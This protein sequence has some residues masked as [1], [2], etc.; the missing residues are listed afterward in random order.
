MSRKKNYFWTSYSDLMTSLFLIMLVLFVMAFGLF[1]KKE[2]ILVDTADSLRV[3]LHKH[4]QILRLEEQMKPLQ[5]DADFY[6]LAEC[7]K[8]V[9]RGLMGIEIFNPFETE[10]IEEYRNIAIDAGRKI[11]S[12]LAGLD[13]DLQYLLV[14]EGNTANTYDWRYNED[15]AS[16]YLRSYRRA[17][18][19]YNLWIEND[20]HFRDYNVEVLLCG[21]G[22]SGLCRDTTEDNNKR[23]SVQLIPKVS[24]IQMSDLE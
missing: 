15:D 14:I 19:V 3:A 5:S 9:F 23:F 1:K 8:F 10:I 11:E 16:G 24:H 22:F 21:S 4:E 6:Y 20:I 12:F 7:E 13:N 18:A 2:G 17:L